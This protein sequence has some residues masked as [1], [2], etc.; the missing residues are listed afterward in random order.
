MIAELKDVTFFRSDF[1]AEQGLQAP[2]ELH[3]ALSAGKVTIY[4]DP[5]YAN[6]EHYR[7]VAKFDNERFY[8]QCRKLAHY[9]NTVLVSEYMINQPNFKLIKS[10]PSRKSVHTT[11]GQDTVER[12][13]KCQ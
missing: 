8:E 5:P 4:C 9:G 6:A 10:I 12:L 3:Q 7:G 11:Y 1:L 2:L 13:Y